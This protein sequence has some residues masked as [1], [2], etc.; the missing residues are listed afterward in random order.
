VFEPT[1]LVSPLWVVVR[2]VDQSTLFVPDVFT[3]KAKA[4]ALA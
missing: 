4:I 2:K 3:I 1:G